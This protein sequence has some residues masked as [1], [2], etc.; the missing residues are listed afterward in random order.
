MRLKKTIK[1]LIIINIFFI[2]FSYFIDTNRV[3]KEK[4]LINEFIKYSSYSTN[5]KSVKTKPTYEMILKIDKINLYKGLYKK[6]SSKNNVNFGL[7]LL[8]DSRYPNEENS[9]IYIASHSGNS[10]I[11]YF[12]NLDLLK[13]NDLAS[14]YYKNKIYTYQLKKIEYIK[15]GTSLNTYIENKKALILITCKKNTDLQ[16]IFIF[17]LE[18]ESLY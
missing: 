2:L 12:R 16:Y 8:D 18:N 7:E 6:N 15:K 14:L 10:K 11:A 1:Y 13:I 17:Y 9:I 4:K 3:I 5:T